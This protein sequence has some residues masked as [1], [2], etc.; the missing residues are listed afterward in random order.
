MHNWLFRVNCE[1][2]TT[3]GT[4]HIKRCVCF[5]K[6]AI[7]RGDNIRF[8]INNDVFAKRL[9]EKEGLL[10]DIVEKENNI[11][12]DCI[13]DFVFVDLY[14]EY[15]ND[16]SMNYLRSIGNKTIVITD[17]FSQENIKADIIVACN[18][19]Q[20]I[21]NNRNNYLTGAKYV[22]AEDDFFKKARYRNYERIEKILV[23]FGGYDPFNVT[24]KAVLALKLINE[25]LKSVEIGILIGSFYQYKEILEETLN[26]SK[27]DYTIYQNVDDICSFMDSFDYAITAAG[28]VFY[29]LCIL[30]IP[31]SV[32]TQTDRQEQ[33]QALLS[34][35]LC[36]DYIG[37]HLR[38]SEEKIA[39]H[40]RRMI[41]AKERRNR[42]SQTCINYFE[43]D[44]KQEI[45]NFITAGV[46]CV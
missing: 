16:E 29:E 12:T 22:I 43:S 41:T 11:Q 6:Y 20:S 33:A 42:M 17:S 15:L 13:Y 10:F 18:E 3:V 8:A 23:T 30:G 9:L 24:L 5:A 26:N 46:N 35:K 21:Y 31:C 7:T 19:A 27:Y 2:N 25:E 1:K 28:N 32:I 45:Y 40:I 38:V 44:G 14:D 37:F 4:G 36:F 39:D 34:N